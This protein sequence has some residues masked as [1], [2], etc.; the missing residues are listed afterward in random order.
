MF[1]GEGGRETAYELI[2]D[3]NTLRPPPTLQLLACKVAMKYI[4]LSHVNIEIK[5]DLMTKFSY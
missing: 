5:I 4:S 2:V 3:T 1:I